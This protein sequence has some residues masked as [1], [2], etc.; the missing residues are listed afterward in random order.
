MLGDNSFPEHVLFDPT[1]PITAVELFV[2]EDEN[3]PERLFWSL[4]YFWL[5]EKFWLLNAVTWPE[6]ILQEARKCDAEGCV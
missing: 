6:F 2:S 1:S 5:N 4:L 3:G